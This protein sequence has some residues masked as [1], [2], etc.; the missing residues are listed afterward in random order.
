MSTCFKTSAQITSG[1][2]LIFINIFVWLVPPEDSYSVSKPSFGKYPLP[3]VTAYWYQFVPIDTNI[4]DV[5]NGTYNLI[6][7]SERNRNDLCSWCQNYHQRSFGSPSQ[8]GCRRAEKRGQGS[9]TWTNIGPWI[10]R[11]GTGWLRCPPGLCFC[12]EPA[13]KTFFFFWGLLTDKAW[14]WGLK[15]L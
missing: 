15:V 11:L 10:W 14:R 7:L 9:D 8:Q 13:I 5:R 1:E 3:H 12:E 6:T 4:T 2:A